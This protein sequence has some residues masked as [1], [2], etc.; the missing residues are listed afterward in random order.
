M[1]M[2]ELDSALNAL[3]ARRVE[4]PDLRAAVRGKIAREGI[5]AAVTGKTVTLFAGTQSAMA[6]SFAAAVLIGIAAHF[7]IQRA[8]LVPDNPRAEAA[9]AL[10]LDIFQSSAMLRPEPFFASREP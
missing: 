3:A 1:K 10:H 9:K 4:A 8:V 2:D 6:L 7:A 5:G